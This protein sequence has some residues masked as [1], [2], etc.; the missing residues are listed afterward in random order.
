MKKKKDSKWWQGVDE[1]MKCLEQLQ[2]KLEGHAL[3]QG[4]S[5]GA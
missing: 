3:Y 1:E 4:Q 5:V 2:E